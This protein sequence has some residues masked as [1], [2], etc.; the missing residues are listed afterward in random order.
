METNRFESVGDARKM[1]LWPFWGEFMRKSLLYL[2]IGLVAVMAA[3]NEAQ[4]RN[5]GYSN[6]LGTWCGNVS[7]YVFTRQS[8]T[9]TW[10][11]ESGK[12]VLPIKGYMFSKTR[13]NVKWEPQ[14]NTIFGEF[15]KDNHR[16]AQLPNT[17]GDM[18][19]RRLFRRCQ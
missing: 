14:G 19:P 3:E 11:G 12:R 17:S 6:I 4:A 16:M 10:Y 1:G 18:G 9:V 5:L 8:L 7:K 15:S 2:I 13:I